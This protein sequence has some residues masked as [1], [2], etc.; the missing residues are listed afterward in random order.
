MPHV[1]LDVQHEKTVLSQV[2]GD[3]AQPRLGRSREYIPLKKC[4]VP[5]ARGV[6]RVAMDNAVGSGFHQS[7][8][9]A[10]EAVVL[11][12]RQ[13][14]HH[15][16]RT[17]FAVRTF[18]VAIIPALDGDSLCKTSLANQPLGALALFLAERDPDARRSIILRG[19]DQ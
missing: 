8:D 9:R 19:K 4:I 16:D 12:T 13:M 14:R 1:V 6:A 2:A 10:E 3:L 15:A 17:H 5:V 7:S 18:E 11:G